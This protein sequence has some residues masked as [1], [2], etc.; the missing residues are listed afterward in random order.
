MHQKIN[1]NSLRFSYIFQV[2]I[3]QSHFYFYSRLIELNGEVE[4]NPG[5]NSEPDE[6]FSICHWNLNSISAHNF[7]KIQSVIAYNCIDHS[8]IICFSETH[9]NSDISSN[10]ENLFIPGYRFIRSD[11]PS[12]DK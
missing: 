9:L 5:P 4:K 6:G 10:N 1:F 12:N 3:L 11:H 8:D 7:S 2:L